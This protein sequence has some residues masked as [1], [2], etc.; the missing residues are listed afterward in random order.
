MAVYGIYGFTTNPDFNVVQTVKCITALLNRYFLF[1]Q[2]FQNVVDLF[3]SIIFLQHKSP[4][5]MFFAF[6]TSWPC[7]SRVTMHVVTPFLYTP[8]QGIAL[9]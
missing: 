6:K 9:I 4:E 5:E 1:N 8:L 3:E 2:Y 7:D